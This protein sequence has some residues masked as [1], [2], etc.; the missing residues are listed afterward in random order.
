MKTKPILFSGPMMRALLEG[1]KTQ[2]RRILKW[3]GDMPSPHKVDTDLGFFILR[4]SSGLRQ[5]V[6]MQFRPGDYLWVRETWNAFQFSQDG[7]EAWPT[8]KIPTLEEIREMDELAYR[9]GAP[10][11]IHRESDRAHKWFA[12]QKWRPGIHMPRFASRLTLRVT[13][14]RAER[15]QGISKEDALAE[16]VHPDEQNWAP[17]RIYS[18]NMP[19]H[20]FGMLWDSLNEK[21]GFGWDVNPWVVANTFELIHKNVDEVV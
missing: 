10:Q 3:P 19:A 6:N 4:W 18:E 13:N 9:Y 14:V 12:D 20:L 21:R 2:T 16:G 5:D 8:P 15:L 7:D 11:I 17:G 1:R